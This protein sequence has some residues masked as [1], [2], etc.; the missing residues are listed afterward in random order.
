MFFVAAAFTLPASES[1]ASLLLSDHPIIL[2]ESD[3]IKRIETP[4][5]GRDEP[6]GLLLSGGSARAFAHIGVL[7]R[8]EEAGYAPDF[9]VTNSMGS[10]VGLLYGAGFSPDAILSL[11]QTFEPSSLFEP[12]IPLRGGILNPGNFIELIEEL[13]P[14]RDL[15][16]LPIPVL[17]VCEDLRTKRRVVLAE[18][19]FSTVL[20]ASFALPFY[21][22]PQ[23]LVNLR[24]IDGGVTNLAPMEVPYTYSD[25][26]LVSTTFYQKQLN[27]S[28]PVTNLNVAM[29]IGKSRRAVSSIKQFDPIWIRCN[30]EKFSFMD[31]NFIEEIATRGYESASR[32]LLSAQGRL[33]GIPSVDPIYLTETRE[34]A[35]RR[36]ARETAQYHRTG[37][38]HVEPALTGARIGI[39]LADGQYDQPLF[40]DR[41]R[42]TAGAYL[43]YG[44]FDAN[45]KLMYQPGYLNRYQM[46]QEDFTGT[47]LNIIWMPGR[48]IRFTVFNDLNYSF[49]ENRSIPLDLHSTHS[50]GEL[51]MP[52][53]LGVDIIGGPAAGAELSTDDEL[54][55]ENYCYYGGLRAYSKRPEGFIRNFETHIT[56]NQA[57]QIALQ[58]E[59]AVNQ[60]LVG[61][62][63]LNQRLFTRLPVAHSEQVTYHPADY[64]TPLK[65]PEQVD[66]L[67]IANTKALLSFP[68]FQPTFGETL[69]MEQ[70]SIGPFFDL[71]ETGQGSLNYAVGGGLQTALSLLGLKPIS[72]RMDAGWSVDSEQWFFSFVLWS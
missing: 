36:A 43:K 42:F 66:R 34:T 65:S 60:K 22:P 53:R 2:G 62:L 39:Q 6:L 13:V 10:I 15:S 58:A 41:N 29:D 32:T 51:F 52:F 27:L 24:L 23:N 47:A 9:I 20:A 38:V 30:V 64:Y 72:M 8:L 56:T 54:S 45:L 17:V 59:I 68:R 7:K 44:N 19:N 70:F 49:E 37:M 16:E 50:S 69:L 63:R 3:F 18:G 57:D 31:W 28:N 61:P 21:F 55:P 46:V 26:V 5:S 33:E 67:I 12:E 71:R 40:G 1:E 14:Y 48:L 35:R 4:L 25:T 11:F